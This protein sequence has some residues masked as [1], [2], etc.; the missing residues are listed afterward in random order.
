MMDIMIF[1]IPAN[2]SII[3]KSNSLKNQLKKNCFLACDCNKDGS[4]SITCT[5]QGGKCFCK[6]TVG[7]DKCD[8]CKAEHFGFP[9]CERMYFEKEIYKEYFFLENTILC[10]RL[11]LSSGRIS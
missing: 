4:K 11:W 5:E 2:V 10:F 6:D 1:Q 9:T 3:S 8:V 7:G